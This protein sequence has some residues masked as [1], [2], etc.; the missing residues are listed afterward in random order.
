MNLLRLAL[1]P[2][3]VLVVVAAAL[4]AGAAPADAK[5][6]WG[7]TGN[8]TIGRAENDGTGVLPSFLT[9]KPSV[10]G[11]GL[12]STHL[13]YMR[14][15]GSA[16]GRTDLSNGTDQPSFIN[17]GVSDPY[18]LVTDGRYLYWAN[19]NGP[20]NVGKTI[21]RSN[22]DGTGV[23]ALIQLDSGST[24]VGV[25]IF[26][27]KIYFSDAGRGWIGRANL[28]GTNVEAS[29]ITGANRPNG[30]AANGTHVFWTN[31]NGGTIGRATLDRSVVQQ[32][33]ITGAS[34]PFM[35]ALDGTSIFWSN[36]S[37]TTIGRAPL[38]GSNPVQ[39]FIRGAS[40]PAGLAVSATDTDGDGV[41][42][43]ADNCPND[44]NQTQTDA[45][46]DGKGDACDPT[47]AAAPAALAFSSRDVDAPPSDTMTSTVTNT[48]TLLVMFNGITT[49][50]SDAAQF[51]RQT[52]QLGDCTATTVLTAGMSCTVRAH[53]APSSVGAKTA[54][55][56]ITSNAPDLVI[57]LSGQGTRTQLSPSPAALA[58]GA[59]DIDDPATASQSTTI[60]NTGTE[61]VTLTALN[62]TGIN[63]NDFE[64]LTGAAGDC[65]TTTLAAGAQCTVRLRFKA[66]T[67]GAKSAALTVTSNAPTVTVSLTGRGTQTELTASPTS[68][69]LGSQDI[70]DGTSSTV[71][72]SVVTNTG[73]ESVN[74]ASNGLGG[75]AAGDFAFADPQSGDCAVGTTLAA[76]S[77]CNVRVRFNPSAVGTRSATF[78]VQTTAPP[79][80]VGL[81]GEGIQ[82]E[83]SGDPATVA[84]GDRD[85]DDDASTARAATIKNSGTEPV[86]LRTIT[87]AG[88]DAGSFGRP[89]AANG[90]CTT[91]T[92]LTAGRTCVVRVTFDPSAIGERTATLTVSSD[93]ADV[94]VTLTG[95]GTESRKPTTTDDV[96]GEFRNAPVRVTLTATDAGGSG[97]ASIEYVVGDDPADPTAEG[98]DPKTYDPANKPLLRDGQKIR[99]SARDGAGNVEAA[100]LSAAAKVDEL[101]PT[102]VDD[103][104]DSPRNTS[105]PVTL[106]AADTGGSG[107][108]NTR[109]LIG[110]DP[111]DPADAANNPK[112]YDSANKPTLRNG[113]RI[114]YST[115][116]KAGNVETAR[117]SVAARIDPVAPDAPAKPVLSALAAR[118]R[119]VRNATPIAPLNGFRGMAFS[120]RLT[121]DAQVTYVIRRRKGTP[122]RNVC[123]VPR[124]TTPGRYT[125]VTK[126]DGKGTAGENSTTLATTSSLRSSAR[127]I[128]TAKAGRTRV[129]LAQIAKNQKLRPGTYTLTITATD[130]FDQRSNSTKVKFWVLNPRGG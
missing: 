55:V 11:L 45:D 122:G 30:I 44:A 3:A 107:V 39:N 4:L 76:G 96:P 114:R 68:L 100:K 81:T 35:V 108:A 74:F 42:D 98:S 58:F 9:N 69:D 129:T 52:D 83:L 103:V 120:F 128:R 126:Q 124:G 88:G 82:T 10:V 71:R 59:K 93:A 89:A 78:T 90:D 63:A 110:I 73:T 102:T 115:V 127:R 72:T 49:T 106:T 21:S 43:G 26:G 27:S 61:N 24:P 29:F 28:D 34:S 130:R 94:T 123:P 99:Y 31:T 54:G 20:P 87:I 1:R 67:T 79:V 32:D 118:S 16:I 8:A 51:E 5:I 22:I 19:N 17:I 57:P 25:A 60:S 113:E 86:D 85:I 109:F 13:H 121:T 56:T 62:V 111:A 66:T 47:L 48:G 75:T 112:T 95:T 92:R 97:V 18:Q 91:T 125:E 119:C 40:N 37:S 64:R 12:T 117:T 77:S 70:D 15:A 53:F 116:D 50:G 14:Q 7:N 33:F 38:D 23:R 6:Y 41:I 105:L 2:L 46:G 84:F 101:K 36:S 80:T 65:T 104:P